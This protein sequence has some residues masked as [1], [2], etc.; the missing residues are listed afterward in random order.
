M[1]PYLSVLYVLADHPT[2]LTVQL[3]LVWLAGHGW[4]QMNLPTLGSL[5][6]RMRHIYKLGGL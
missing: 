1:M 6:C 4:S 3:S 2:A 5:I